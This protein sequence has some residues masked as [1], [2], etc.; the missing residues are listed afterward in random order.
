VK[1]VN[2]NPLH[3]IKSQENFHKGGGGGGNHL[4]KQYE[5]E[6]KFKSPQK[7]SNYFLG[8]KL[9]KFPT[10]PCIKKYNLQANIQ[11]YYVMLNLENNYV[12]PPFPL[13][14]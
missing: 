1:I 2:P 14:L 13:V 9:S 3:F 7:K 6:N 11:P 12:F 5:K 4:F 8:I 10:I